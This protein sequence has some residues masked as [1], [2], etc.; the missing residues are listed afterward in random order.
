MET[1]TITKSENHCFGRKKVRC[2][3][4]GG[5]TRDAD[6]SIALFNKNSGIRFSD[7]ITTKSQLGAKQ[8][9]T[10]RFAYKWASRGFRYSE[11]E[12]LR[13]LQTGGLV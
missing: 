4:R 12:L 5:T 10:L 11:T 13:C 7:G 6:L 9:D 2:K 1:E 3:S 8:H